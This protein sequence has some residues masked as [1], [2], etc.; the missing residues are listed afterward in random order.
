MKKKIE[1]IK[2]MKFFRNLQKLKIKLSFFNYY[3]TFMN[4]YVVIIRS[5]MKLKIKDFK[6]SS[7]KK[8]SKRKHV[9]RIRFRKK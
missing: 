3:R 2:K 6:D 4:H 9:I 7:I 1:T 5:L 8:R